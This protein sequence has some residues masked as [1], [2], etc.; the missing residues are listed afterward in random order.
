MSNLFLEIISLENLFGSWEEF[1]SDKR[2]KED[3]QWFERNLENNL[4]KLFFELKNKTYQHSNYTSFYIT[5]PKLRHI[6]KAIVKDRIVHHAIYRI[7]YPLFDKSFIFDSYSCRIDKGTHKAVKRFETFS[8]KAS[9]NYTETCYVLKCDIKKFFDSVDHIILENLLERKIQDEE[10]L[11][12]LSNIIGSF[13]GQRNDQGFH[14]ISFDFAN[15][16]GMP[17]GN[18]TSQLFANIYLNELDRFVKQVLGVKYY[19]RY[20]DDFVILD[21]DKEK[22]EIIKSRIDNFLQI[23]LK[24]TLHEGKV[25]IRKLNQGIDFLGYVTKPH[26]RVLRTKTKKRILNRINE[27]NLQSYLGVLK[28][29]NAYKLETRIKEIV[30]SNIKF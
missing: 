6:H 27:T 5:D 1:K 12:L 14:Q 23:N 18:L 9:R 13:G 25:S 30:E 29:C 28:H 22:L 4:F 24:L 11:R 3:V 2:R 10:V 20:C 15:P 21:L 26:F 19:I 16:R 17:I 8:R 7:L